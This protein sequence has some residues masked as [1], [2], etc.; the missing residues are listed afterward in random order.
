MHSLIS[1]IKQSAVGKWLVHFYPYAYFKHWD[2]ALRMV[3]EHCPGM[4]DA[5]RR[6]VARRMIK[7]FCR[8]H[9]YFDEFLCYGLQDLKKPVDPD[10]LADSDRMYYVEKLNAIADRPVF[11]DKYATYLKFR[12]FYKRECCMVRSVADGIDFLRRHDSFIAKPVDAS[13]GNGVRFIVRQP[14]ELAEDCLG[15]VLP[16]NAQGVLLEERIQQ[17]QEMADFHPKSVNTIR[18]SVIR[19]DDHVEVFEPFMRLGRGDAVVDN[20]GQGGLIA[21]I[22]PASGEVFACG[23]EHGHHYEV[24]PDSGKRIIGFKIPRWREAC[25]LGARL[26]QVIPTTR[27]IGWDLALTEKGWDIV[28]GNEMA[29]FLVQLVTGRGIRSRLDQIVKKLED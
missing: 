13:L 4:D 20:A 29:Q 14:G 18:M 21:A 12:D 17:V 28:E 15:R 10:W 11:A 5:S 27:Y 22:D 26:A 16:P 2:E 1:K 6:K 24:H 23:D 8:H 9:F 7:V 25:E 3:G 19:M